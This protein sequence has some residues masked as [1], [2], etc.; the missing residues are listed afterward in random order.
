MRALLLVLLLTACQPTPISDVLPAFSTYT[1]KQQ[2][3]MKTDF[4]ALPQKSS[5]RTVIRDCK[6]LRDEIRASK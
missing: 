3:Q 5:L 1:P 4:D 6:A 2:R